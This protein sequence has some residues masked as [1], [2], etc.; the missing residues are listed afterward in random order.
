MESE[1]PLWEIFQTA[2]KKLGEKIIIMKP[3]KDKWNGI[4]EIVF[5]SETG[6]WVDHE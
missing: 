2:P 5:L 6:E 3:V 1:Q 4:Q